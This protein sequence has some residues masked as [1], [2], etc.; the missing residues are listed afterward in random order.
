MPTKLTKARL[1]KILRDKLHLTD[2]VFRLEVYSSRINGLVISDS[3]KRKG[4]SQRQ[5]MIWDALESVLGPASVKLVGMILAYTPEEWN[6][7][8]DDAVAAGKV[9]AR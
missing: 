8:S 6:L 7:G 2:P 4:D 5:K 1:E 3:F 9:K